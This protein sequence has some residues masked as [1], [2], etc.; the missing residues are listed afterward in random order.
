MTLPH[1]IVII[2]LGSNQGA[3][4][5]NVQE[6]MERLQMLSDHPI[7]RSSLWESEPVDC[8]PGSPLFVNAVVALLPRLE[9]TPFYLHAK[10]QALEIEFGRRP[11][12]VL[13]EPRPLDLDLIAFGRQTLQ[14]STLILPHPRAALRR[15]V[16]GPLAEIDPEYRLPGLSCSV[17]ELLARLPA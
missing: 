12:V 8:P 16:L 7:C 13:N 5:R 4:R 11:K 3:P 10:T 1:E 14:T 6:A 15:F 17:A 9:E 2:A